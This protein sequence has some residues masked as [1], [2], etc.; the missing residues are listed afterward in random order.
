MLS[1]QLDTRTPNLPVIPYVNQHARSSAQCASGVRAPDAGVPDDGVRAGGRTMDA[2][3]DGERF[4][5]WISSARGLWEALSP[6]ARARNT[7]PLRVL[8]LYTGTGEL[9]R[10]LMLQAR[11]AGVGLCVDGCDPCADVLEVASE[12]ARAAGFALDFFAL[13][14]ERACVPEGYDVLISSFRLHELDADRAR[15]L[16]GAMAR[17]TGKLV[18]VQDLT[19]G[20]IGSGLAWLAHHLGGPLRAADPTRLVESAWTVDE[21]RGMASAAGMAQAHV[22]PSGPLRWQLSWSR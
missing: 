8:D 11:R 12:R 15:W 17:H 6:M 22:G 10:A 9:P 20:A 19:R 5:G 7:R 13:D 14:P 4:Q 16:L 1:R 2:I 3:L 18:I 21:V